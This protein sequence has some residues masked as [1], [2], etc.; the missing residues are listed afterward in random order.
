MAGSNGR[1]RVV[2]IGGYSRSGS[3][4]LLRLLAESPGLTAVG[5]LFDVWKR[6]YRDDQLCGCGRGFHE[7]PF[8]REV[9][10]RAFGM[11]PAE[12]PWAGFEARRQRVQGH[13]SIP[14]LW[15]P[16]LRSARYR[17]ELRRY[18]GEIGRLFRAIFEVSNAEVVLES[19]KVPQFAWVLSE[20][21]DVDVHMVHLIR[22]SRAAAFSWTRHKVRPEISWKVQAMDRH[23]VARSALEWS[24]FNTMLAT[25]RSAFASYTLLR[26]ED[27]VE[28]P[29][30]ELRRIETA[31]GAP[32]A[33]EHLVEG[34]AEFGTAHTASGNPSRFAVG[35]VR[36]KRDDEWV[37]G[38]A[39]KD[40]RIV[41]ALTLPGLHRYGYAMDPG[42]DRERAS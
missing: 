14:R 10:Q 41:T 11:K 15:V 23:T 12:L 3:T 19:S 4:L 35:P 7:C 34:T 24:V 22:D 38:L 6:S 8:W 30:R 21:P 39:P 17:S 28:D 16:A 25:R 40:R 32:L 2:Y 27:L 42:A 13:A 33:Y 20:I 18:A 5:E 1:M 37:L 26:Y 9:T 29:A 36:I 31:V